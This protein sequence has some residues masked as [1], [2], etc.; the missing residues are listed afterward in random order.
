MASVVARLKE[1]DGLT[2]GQIAKLGGIGRTT[3]TRWCNGD[4]ATEGAPDPRK[5]IDFHHR[6]GVNPE[7]GLRALG[8]PTDEHDSPPADPVDDGDVLALLD[9]LRDPNVALEDKSYI[10]ETI[11]RLTAQARPAETLPAR[12]RH[13][14]G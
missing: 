11:R 4:W 7:P 12:R 1:R 10:R 9:L 2:N 6:V 8:L 14:A 5:V 13:A 3:L